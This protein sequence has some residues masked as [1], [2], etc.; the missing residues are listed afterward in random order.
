VVGQILRHQYPA[1]ACWNVRITFESPDQITAFEAKDLALEGTLD[2][3][4]FTQLQHLDLSG[5]QALPILGDAINQV[6]FTVNL[7]NNQQ[8]QAIESVI[9]N[10]FNQNTGSF[11]NRSLNLLGNLEGHETL[12]DQ[13]ISQINALT[14][15]GWTV[16]I[17]YT[18]VVAQ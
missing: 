1:A 6:G 16:D 18:K 7:A 5:N 2:F 10:I 15:N 4:D 12:P 8:G 17:I 13:T 11:E 9:D 14:A 3:S